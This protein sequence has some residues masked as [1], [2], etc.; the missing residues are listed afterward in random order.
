MRDIL[1]KISTGPVGPK[2][3]EIKSG[4]C[5]ASLASK[6][7]MSWERLWN[8]DRN[9][10]L[11]IT[12]RHPG[13]LL[14]GD[15]L[16]IPEKETSQGKRAVDKEYTFWRKGLTCGIQLRFTA[17]GQ[18]RAGEEYTASNG[19]IELSRGKLDAKGM[20]EIK[21]PI[22][23][24]RTVTVLVGKNK[25]KY[26]FELGTL[27]PATEARGIQTR[28]WN[29]GYYCGEFSDEFNAETESALR[30]FLCKNGVINKE[31]ETV[32]DVALKNGLAF[33]VN[34]HGS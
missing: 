1:E 15:T 19:R 34:A 16:S 30:R 9:K 7:G 29:L 22:E 32:N 5:I 33:L 31:N 26:E 14:P 12:R 4:A 8:N 27:A 2:G 18:P 20:A 13:I 11:K 10:P 25:E 28:L 17:F 23:E 6:N 24:C 3:E 21:V